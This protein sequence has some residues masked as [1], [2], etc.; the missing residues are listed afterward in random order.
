MNRP[1]NI[2]LEGLLLKV[3]LDNESFQRIYRRILRKGNSQ[4]ILKPAEATEWIETFVLGNI[5][6]KDLDN[7][8]IAELNST[9][10]MENSKIIYHVESILEMQFLVLIIS[11][12]VQYQTNIEHNKQASNSSIAIET[13]TEVAIIMW[14]L[15]VEHI[16]SYIF[17]FIRIRDIAKNGKPDKNGVYRAPFEQS[18][19]ILEI[20]FDSILFGYTINHMRKMSEAQ[21][22]RQ[23]YY[24][25][26]II[27][28]MII[29]FL[30]QFYNY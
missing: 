15:I 3:K 13:D 21:F 18:L 9:D 22:N 12:Y 7:Q 14:T 19:Q 28:D 25:Y 5:T 30:T 2:S 1:K 24:T 16:G 10:L 17:S 11:T 23:P 20:F 6:K 26:W 29:M 4:N 8:R 27:I